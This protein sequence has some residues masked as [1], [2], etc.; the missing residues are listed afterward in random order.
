MLSFC[1]DLMWIVICIL[2]VGIKQGTEKTEVKLGKNGQKTSL[3]GCTYYAVKPW[4][5]MWERTINAN[6]PTH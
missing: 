2:V 5:P 6:T 1:I 4:D 3:T